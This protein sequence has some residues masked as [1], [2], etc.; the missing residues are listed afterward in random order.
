[1]YHLETFDFGSDSYN[2]VEMVLNV[3]GVVV[4]VVD[5]ERLSTGMFVVWRLLWYFSVDDK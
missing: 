5:L 1:M 2:T 4:S 3:S